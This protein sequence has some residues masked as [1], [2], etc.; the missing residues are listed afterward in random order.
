MTSTR[1]QALMGLFSYLQGLTGP[2]IRRNE[3]LPAIIPEAGL[4]ILRDGQPGEPEILLSPTRYIYQHQAEV[5]VLIQDADQTQRDARLDTLLVAIGEALDAAGTL[6]VPVDVCRPGA[7]EF[8]L[9]HTEG[10]PTVKAAVVPVILEYSTL[11]PL[12]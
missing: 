9:E 11:N 4:I 7:P 12:Q 10:A 6:G 8:L 5:E 1:E 2:D 3:P